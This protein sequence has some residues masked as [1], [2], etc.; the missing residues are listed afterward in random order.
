[1]GKEVLSQS[2][3]HEDVLHF[4]AADK[5]VQISICLQEDVVI[6]TTV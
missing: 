6:A 3:L 2:R 5:T 1:M 4:M